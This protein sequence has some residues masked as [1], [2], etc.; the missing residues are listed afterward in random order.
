M[1]LEQQHVTQI[2]HIACFQLHCEAIVTQT[3]KVSLDA[4]NIGTQIPGSGLSD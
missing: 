4:E 3:V 1:C 2:H